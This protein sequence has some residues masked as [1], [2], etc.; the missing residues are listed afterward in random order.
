MS[1]H[2]DLDGENASVI[3]SDVR[4]MI[5]TTMAPAFVVA[6]IKVISWH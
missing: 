1:R 4:K 2:L 5:C 6:R 3:S